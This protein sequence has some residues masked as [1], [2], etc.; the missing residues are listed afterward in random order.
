[1]TAIR[2]LDAGVFRVERDAQPPWVARVFP[3]RRPVQASG[4]DAEILRFLARVDFPAERCAQPSPVTT[5][6]EQAVLVTEYVAGRACQG[7]RADF[8]RLV[9]LLGRLHGVP[10]GPP[11]A[12]RPGGAWHHVA[13]EGRPRDEIAA[14]LSLLDDAAPRVAASQQP[15][16]ETLRHALPGAEDCGDLPESLI[17]P[18]FAPANAIVS[19]S[20]EITVVDWTGA[21]RGP[22]LWPLAFLLWAAGA[23]GLRCVDSIVAGYRHHG[24]L[25]PAERER[26]AGA[27]AARPLI[28]ACWGFATGREQLPDVVASLPIIQ[29]R[30]ARVAARAVGALGQLQ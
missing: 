5:H 21:G 30:A 11:A 9:D 16:H 2:R 23:Q 13:G 1:M 3:S 15:L 12:A 28:F 8:R 4:D 24:Q 29:A 26:L 7:S 6:H 27:I 25:E 20:G 22:R 18:D 10:P 17:H 14:T 19:P